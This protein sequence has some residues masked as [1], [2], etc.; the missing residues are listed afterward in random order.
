M[1]GAVAGGD[2]T[3]KIAAGGCEVIIS[4]TLRY[5][6]AGSTAAGRAAL[7]YS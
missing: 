6:S 1:L 2:T 3:S 4:R 7:A 5:V